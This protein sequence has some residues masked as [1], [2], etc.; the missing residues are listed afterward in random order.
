MHE[1]TYPQTLPVEGSVI[2]EGSTGPK[3]HLVNDFSF[4]VDDV[5]W[6]RIKIQFKFLIM[7]STNRRKNPPINIMSNGIYLDPCNTLCRT[8]ILW[9]TDIYKTNC[10]YCQHYYISDTKQNQYANHQC[11][12][13]N[14]E[15]PFP[16]SVQNAL[17]PS[18]NTP[19][20]MCHA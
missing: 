18:A 9:S 20:S 14:P 10:D 12:H 15:T 6:H 16:A 5:T 3:G 19:L 2:V 7:A 4:T 1:I 13:S 11:C 17:F 8:S